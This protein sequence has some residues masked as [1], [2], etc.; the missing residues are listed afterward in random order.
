MN[1]IVQSCIKSD[2]YSIHLLQEARL[3]ALSENG[4]ETAT[5]KLKEVRVD[6]SS[7]TSI[8]WND[9]L[10][11]SVQV[12]NMYIHVLH[13]LGVCRI[14]GYWCSFCRI[15]SPQDLGSKSHG[16]DNNML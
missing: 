14:R 13:I 11:L 1:L 12:S 2:L 4:D 7:L 10:F 9:I 6:F 3:V 5:E 16:L 15:T 8:A